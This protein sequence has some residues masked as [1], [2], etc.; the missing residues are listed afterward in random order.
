MATGSR[1]L[2]FGLFCLQVK[3]KADHTIRITI[4]HDSAAELEKLRGLMLVLS[5]TLDTAV[6]VPVYASNDAA[7]KSGR[8]MDTT[9][10]L[11]GSAAAM[12]LGPIP[13]EKLPKDAAPGKTLVGSL[14]L[15]ICSG[16][17]KP[18]PHSVPLAMPCP[19]PKLKDDA[20]KDSGDKKTSKT[21]AEK[22]QEAVRDT[23]VQGSALPACMPCLL[24]R[25]MLF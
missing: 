24:R 9:P 5:R 8:T 22:L 11:H 20:K 23:K 6:T 1:L 12:F 14:K 17:G 7:L 4:R 25:L 19:P 18:A 3:K 10:L 16:S 2:V 21:E 15:G 13:D